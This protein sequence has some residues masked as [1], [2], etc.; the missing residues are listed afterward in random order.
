MFLP[1]CVW[2]VCLVLGS[3]KLRA[4]PLSHSDLLQIFSFK[5]HISKHL[6]PHTLY[7][8]IYIW[9][10]MDKLWLYS[11]RGS[12]TIYEHEAASL[13]QP[14][15]KRRLGESR[16]STVPWGTTICRSITLY[17]QFIQTLRIH[18]PAFPVPISALVQSAFKRSW[19]SLP[20]GNTYFYVCILLHFLVFIFFFS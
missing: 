3:Y 6:L 5:N 10:H 17:H 13:F 12:G 14:T 18:E 11:W 8:Y 19:K 20:N 7:I 2:S 9:T 4:L 1:D 16:T 15:S